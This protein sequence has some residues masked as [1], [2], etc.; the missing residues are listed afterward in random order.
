MNLKQEAALGVKD[1]D[2]HIDLWSEHISP[3]KHS[4][5]WT[6]VT[7]VPLLQQQPSPCSECLSA[8]P[9][10]ISL[11]FWQEGKLLTFWLEMSTLW[12]LILLYFRFK[13][14]LD[15]SQAVKGLQH[16]R[17]L[18]GFSLS[19]NVRS[20][21]IKMSAYKTKVTAPQ[22]LEIN[23]SKSKTLNHP[24]LSLLTL[25]NF[26]EFWS[27]VGLSPDSLYKELP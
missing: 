23:T 9:D 19:W 5:T 11:L 6:A 21:H 12:F 18:L 3:Y 24:E 10:L 26:F 20:N 2:G 25:M 27:D 17:T 13:L 15:C 7:S 16:E 1:D 8:A 22:L 14:F 4:S